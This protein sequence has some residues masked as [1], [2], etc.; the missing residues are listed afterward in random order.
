[1][2]DARNF[3]RIL[4]LT[5]QPAASTEKAG[6]TLCLFKALRYDDYPDATFP[7]ALTVKDSTSRIEFY[8]YPWDLVDVRKAEQERRVKEEVEEKA[9]GEGDDGRGEEVDKGPGI[10]EIGD[11]GPD[12]GD[13]GNVSSEDEVVDGRVGEQ[14][15]ESQK[16]E[17][18]GGSKAEN[19]KENEESEEPQGKDDNGPRYGKEEEEEH[20]ISPPHP[21]IGL[22]NHVPYAITLDRVVRLATRWLSQCDTSHPKCSPEPHQLPRRLLDLRGG[23]RLIDTT[24]CP[25]FS[26]SEPPEYTT[27]SHCWGLNTSS[28]PL[29]TTTTLTLASHMSPAGIPWSSL[30]RLFQDVILL[31]RSLNF[32]YLWIDSLCILQDSEEDWLTESAN[33]SSIYAHA[34]LNIAA[35]AQRDA[36]AS[37]FR[38]RFHG[39][40]FRDL[41]MSVAGQGAGAGVGSVKGVGKGLRGAMDTVEIGSLPLSM[42]DTYGKGEGDGVQVPVYAR[43]GHDRSHETLFGEVEYFRT[44]KEPILSRAWVF[45]ERLLSRR[46]LHFG[47]SEVLW[48]CK[49]G[50]FCECGGIE[51]GHVLSVRNLNNN[52]A[53]C[54]RAPG[55]SR[56]GD[57]G[58]S[59]LLSP[60]LPLSRSS[61]FDTGSSLTCGTIPKKVLFAN[62]TSGSAETTQDSRLLHDFFLRCVEE[63]SFLSLTKEL[64][65]SFALA[66]IA[67]RLHS[68]LGPEDRYLAGLWLH[69]LPRALLWQPYRHKKVLRAGDNIPTWSW[70]SRSCYPVENL[71]AYHGKARGYWPTASKCSVRYKHIT[72]SGYEFELDDRLEVDIDPEK[73]WCEYEGGNEFGKLK[74][75]QVT[76][77]AACRW[78]V[79]WMTGTKKYSNEWTGRN[80]LVVAIQYDN[81]NGKDDGNG[82]E[83]VLVPMLPDCP[84]HEDP[85]SVALME[86]VLV[87]LFGGRKLDKETG[88]GEADGPQF[89]LA[90]KEVEGREG[91]FQRV[92]FLESEW[93]IDLFDNAEVRTITL[94]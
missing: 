71:A 52:A 13:D 58:D 29:L 34:T 31:V 23:V 68:L 19:D 2:A 59:G 88:A 21:A 33:M 47:S 55:T 44:L 61:T 92:G 60:S 67:K 53:A 16:P 11:E 30:P 26:P 25:L 76:L 49:S 35:T 79:V 38:R 91:V 36:S 48:E 62:L 56:G 93:R 46:T 82:G 51:R 22:A 5:Q 24:T 81:G 89:F 65:R 78:G 70:M 87:V 7:H 3:R 41:K 63:Y 12:D 50:C 15:E 39:Q 94:I 8:C 90:L 64:D 74:G 45:Q 72:R 57:V 66:G 73:T 86:K 40:G 37:L 54:Y 83:G 6:G 9:K 27:L 20:H 85:K 14:L 84:R 75:G 80:N 18:V 17:E 77:T 43:I 10:R 32:Q 1:M 42:G 28:H 69:D 4:C